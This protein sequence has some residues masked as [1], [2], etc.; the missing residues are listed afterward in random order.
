MKTFLQSFYP[1]E[2]SCRTRLK[3]TVFNLCLFGEILGGLDGRLHPLDREEGRQVGGVGAD[4]DQGEEPPHARH[5]PCGDGP[6]T[7]GGGYRD[8]EMIVVVVG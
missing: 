3:T 1:E 2:S 5:H 8:V 6:G 4:H 7:R